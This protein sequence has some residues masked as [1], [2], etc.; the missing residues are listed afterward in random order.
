MSIMSPDNC[1]RLPK[2]G[3]GVDV[4]YIGA[5]CTRGRLPR[6]ISAQMHEQ[7]PREPEIVKSGDD[8]VHAR[9]VWL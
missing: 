9:G 1:L 2:T 6:T 8:S 4:Q 3:I 7:L 5:R